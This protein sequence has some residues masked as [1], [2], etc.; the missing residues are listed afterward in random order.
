MS[1]DQRTPHT[2]ALATLG[3]IISEN[4]KRDAIHLAVEPA[5]AGQTLCPGDD[6]GFAPDGTMMDS[7]EPVGI[8][9]PFLKAPIEK[10][11]RFWLIVYPRQITSLRHVWTHPAFPDAV[12]ES[13]V[14]EA[15]VEDA[16]ESSE[17]RKSRR[18]IEKYAAKIEVD[19]DELIEM[20]TKFLQDGSLWHGGED[21]EGKCVD[22]EFWEQYE[23]VTGR[24]VDEDDRLN[25]FSCSC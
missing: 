25:F 12:Q 1:A 23:V 17:V 2:D 8:V 10:G 14:A 21:F 20:A 19:A 9:D 15:K 11:Q 24:D 13:V 5:I 16:A 18:W 7:L 4:E 22:D 3:T 6:V